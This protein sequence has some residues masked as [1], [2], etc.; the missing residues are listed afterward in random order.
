MK[1]KVAASTVGAAA[2]LAGVAVAAVIGSVHRPV[3]EPV[4]PYAPVAHASVAAKHVAP[5]GCTKPAPITAAGY[6]ALWATLD[7]NHWGAADVSISVPLPDGRIV[8]LYGDTLSTHG[9]V[10]SSAIVQDKGCLHVVNGGAQIFP[11]VDDHHIFWISKAEYLPADHAVAITAR[12]E[13]LTGT[14][15]WDF[16]DGGYDQT[17]LLTL[18]KHGN[19]LVAPVGS[20]KHTPEPASGTLIMLGAHHV[21]YGEQSHPEV[22]LA[23]GKTLYTLC[24]NWDDGKLHPFAE[25]RPIFS[26]K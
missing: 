26:E 12:A 15:A 19:A 25:Y 10:H 8:W 9:F 16:K 23:S 5:V 13:V 3:A 17:A 11:N 2:V 20:A 22:K 21:A 14:G 6:K 18:D 24:Q 7:P 4:T 1:L